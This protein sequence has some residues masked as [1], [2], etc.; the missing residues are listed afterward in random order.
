MLSLTVSPRGDQPL[1]DQIV[2]GIKRQ[3]EDRHPKLWKTRERK[4]EAEVVEMAVPPIIDAAEFEAVQTLLTARAAHHTTSSQDI[5]QAGRRRMRTESGGYRRD[6][7]RALAQR[8]EV[9][10]KELRIMGSKSV[11]LRTLVAASSAKTAGFGVPSFVPKWRARE[12]SNFRP[13]PLE[14]V[15]T[16]L[17]RRVIGRQDRLLTIPRPG[18]VAAGN[19]QALA[20][21]GLHGTPSC[22]CAGR[23]RPPSL[24]YARDRLYSRRVSWP[25]QR[26]LQHPRPNSGTSGRPT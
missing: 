23:Q 7:L 3:I 21:A 8:V 24:G 10:Q 4:P 26:L 22:V 2:A 9:D 5:R 6:N 11:L 19:E 16:A 1:A 20:A 15:N 13:L 12:D 17:S 18:S 25:I 14:A